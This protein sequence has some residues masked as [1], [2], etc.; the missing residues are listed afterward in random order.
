MVGGDH[1]CFVVAEIG[2]NHQGD[3]NIAKE[4]IKKA[5]EAGADAA[6]FQKSELTRRFNRAALARPYT[7]PNAWGPT[8]GE[9][10]S[11]WSSATIST[12]SSRLTP[13][14]KASTSLP[15]Q[16]MRYGLEL[17]PADFLADELDVPFIKVASADA[18]NL[19]YLKHTAS[20]G[21]P[22][23]LSSGMQSMGIMERAVGTVT[24]N[25]PGEKRLVVMQCT[26]TYPL[27]PA[28]VH[29]RCI[30]LFKEKFP[31]AI[32]G[33]SGH[34]SGIAI[35]LAAV[36]LGAKV[37][38]RHVTLDKSW[39]GSDHA[40]SLTFDELKDLCDN[41]RIVETALGKPIKEP[42]PTDI[43]TADLTVIK[44]SMIFTNEEKTTKWTCLYM[45]VQCYD[46]FSVFSAGVKAAEPFG[47]PPDQIY[48]L[49][50]QTVTKA[51]EEDA[52]IPKEALAA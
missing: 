14:S 8:Y 9:T 32:I 51:I 5:K 33:Y 2:Q 17:L 40:A 23:I 10:N 6:K 18:N 24:E 1:P 47:I 44:C 28:D 21:K 25:M 41:I 13:N 37:V 3:I 38:E 7:S 46:V 22:M 48:E 31:H 43:F 20:K 27:P 30:N 4:M 35:S 11:T 50:G 45:N 15:Q 49:V 42:R 16:W 34:E 39:K 19:P 52:T 29:L 36:S 12:R 26:S